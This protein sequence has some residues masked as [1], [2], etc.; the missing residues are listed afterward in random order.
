MNFSMHIENELH[1]ALRKYCFEHRVTMSRVIKAT[2]MKL[3]QDRLEPEE[4]EKLSTWIR[5][6]PGRPPEAES[7]TAQN[8]RERLA[9]L[10]ASNKIREQQ[11]KIE[12]DNDRYRNFGS[13]PESNEPDWPE[14]RKLA[15][16]RRRK[17]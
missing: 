6:E 14:F 16:E 11:R 8:R 10:E 4:L 12:E 9:R 5:R 17:E 1:E 13:P 15:D 3:V 2:M 7:A